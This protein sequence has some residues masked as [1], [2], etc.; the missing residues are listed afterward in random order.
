M[1][2][3]FI[4][5]YQLLQSK[6]DCST[7]LQILETMKL[8]PKEMKSFISLK[9]R[10]LINTNQIEEV[11]MY[12]TSHVLMKR[13]YWLCVEYYYD[14]DI[15]KAIEIMT[16]YIDSIDSND[17][18]MLI[19]NN[20]IELI[21]LWDG[22]PVESTYKSNIEQ[23]VELKK[24]NFDTSEMIEVYRKK[25]PPKIISSF[26]QK[27][28]DSDILID[29]ANISHAGKDFNYSE[30]LKVV[31]ILESKQL[32]PI[33]IL[34]ERHII[35]CP[36]LKKYIVVTPK[37]NY[38]D[39]FLLYGMFRYNKMV[40]SNDL[41][42]DHVIGLNKYIKC[43]IEMMTIKYDENTII[44]PQYSKCIQVNQ[45]IIYIPCVNGFYKISF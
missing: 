3:L 21:K 15:L 30:L 9:L 28:K 45:S 11:I 43:Y 4:E 1:N 42:R 41:F 32:K 5:T 27:I 35:K 6:Q 26:E 10:H 14:R 40:V 16:T 8:K 36:I 29:G 19:R 39:N 38:D 13:D 23:E 34:H 22:H 24:Y 17:I 33:I 7:N 44:I 25:L 18:D 12:L 20:W 31:R 37:N 2:N